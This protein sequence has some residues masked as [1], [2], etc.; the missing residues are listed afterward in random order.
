MGEIILQDARTIRLNWYCSLPFADSVSSLCLFLVIH[1]T[2]CSPPNEAL[3]LFVSTRSLSSCID[4][5]CR[6]HI[7]SS[8]VSALTTSSSLDNGLY[9]QRANHFPAT[10]PVAHPV[11]FDIAIAQACEPYCSTAPTSNDLESPFFLLSL[12]PERS[13]VVPP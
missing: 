12:S 2:T 11:F 4:L 8:L 6:C 10:P 1:A 3:A 5:L 9:C 13:R 7:I